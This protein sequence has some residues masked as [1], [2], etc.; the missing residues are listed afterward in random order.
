[1]TDAD[2]ALKECQ[3]ARLKLEQEYQ[4][5]EWHLDL[6]RREHDRLNDEAAATRRELTRVAGELDECRHLLNEREETI[7]QLKHDFN[8]AHFAL[9]CIRDAVTNCLGDDA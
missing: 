7:V 9:E 2:E 1:M 3:R 8:E 5:L 4:A 6:L